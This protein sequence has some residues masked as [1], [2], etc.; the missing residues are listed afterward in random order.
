MPKL[1][2]ENFQITTSSGQILRKTPLTF[3]ISPGEILVIRGLNGS[4][5]TSLLKNI[6][7]STRAPMPGIRWEPKAQQVTYLPQSAESQFH[8]P[9]RLGDLFNAFSGK[10]F[11]DSSEFLKQLFTKEMSTRSWNQASGGEKKRALLASLLAVK[12]EIILLDEPL[13]HLDS[14][15]QALIENALKSYASLN[16]RA[17]IIVVSHQGFS[18]AG[19]SNTSLLE[20]QL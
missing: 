1:W 5:K 12:P 13:N 8:I 2:V 19:L 16:S 17:V 3:V 11:D 4:G 14:T 7:Q 6:L 10:C 18:D 20:L 9:L 15:S